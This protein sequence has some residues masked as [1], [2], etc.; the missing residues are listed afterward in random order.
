MKDID[1][2]TTEQID[3]IVEYAA[4]FRK[5]DRIASV[6]GV[7]EEKVKDAIDRTDFIRRAEDLPAEENGMGYEDEDAFDNLIAE[8]ASEILA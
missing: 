3:A 5:S 4:G 1:E 6:F 7:T 2:L 8:L